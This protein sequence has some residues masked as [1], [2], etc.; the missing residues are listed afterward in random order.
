MNIILISLSLI[1]NL[2]LLVYLF[3]TIP[4]LLFLSI[5][6]NIFS[7]WY[8]KNLFDEIVD[9][10]EETERISSLLSSFE[11][12]L[13]SLYEMEMFYGDSTLQSLL[14][15]SKQLLE[16]FD[17]YKKQYFY[18]DDEEEEFDIEEIIGNDNDETDPAPE[19]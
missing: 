12:H 7:L 3:G 6:L 5:L 18:E 15:H 11:E 8:I 16:D 2:I 17:I 13:S 10:D 4:V 19:A 9:R 14:E 1:M